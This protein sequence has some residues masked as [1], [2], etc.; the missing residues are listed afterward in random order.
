MTNMKANTAEL[1]E[2]TSEQATT[3]SKRVIRNRESRP[4]Q[5]TF[6]LKMEAIAAKA[7]ELYNLDRFLVSTL[8]CNR[9]YGD[10][11]FEFDD[12]WA[13]SDYE[14]LMTFRAR[15]TAASCYEIRNYAKKHGIKVF[16]HIDDEAWQYFAV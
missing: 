6:S 12:I 3:N 2:I 13:P 14:W 5:K 9:K 4:R 7:E 8:I 16:G 15:A 1:I 10:E 11:G